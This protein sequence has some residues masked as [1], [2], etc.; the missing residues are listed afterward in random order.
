VLFATA[1]YK[2]TIDE[3]GRRMRNLTAISE[4]KKNWN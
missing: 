4:Y 3:R 2:P 1:I